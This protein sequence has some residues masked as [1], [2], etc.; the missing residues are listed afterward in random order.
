[1]GCLF[2]KNVTIPAHTL[3]VDKCI[4]LRELLLCWK[5]GVMP[6]HAELR[7]WSDAKTSFRSWPDAFD[8]KSLLLLF[9]RGGL[10]GTLR[11]K[12]R[13]Y[14]RPCFYEFLSPK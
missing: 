1:M 5:P 14:M 12:L 2:G 10:Q 9:A 13:L 3:T 8:L 4:Q 11:L 6:L 7:A